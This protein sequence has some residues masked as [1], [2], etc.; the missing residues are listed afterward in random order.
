METNAAIVAR[1]NRWIDNAKRNNAGMQEDLTDPHC[2][3]PI[4]LH[5]RIGDNL[6]KIEAWQVVLDVLG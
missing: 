5:H 6:A 2:V 3:N 1:L 4:T